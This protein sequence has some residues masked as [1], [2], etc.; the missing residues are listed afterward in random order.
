MKLLPLVKA[1]GIMALLLTFSAC[2]IT[3]NKMEKQLEHLETL[4]Y[5]FGDASVPPPYHRS[6]TI[7]VNKDSLVL[8]VDS[9]GDTLAEK[10]YTMPKN[11]LQ[12]LGTSLIKHNIHKRAEN[13]QSEGCT[14]G[15]TASIA[16][17]CGDQYEPFYASAYY[18]G[19]KTYGTLAG[20]VDSFLVDLKG[21]VPDL[22]AVIRS[23]E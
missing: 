20:N 8:T 2:I 17:T 19:G 14:G 9:Y 6:Y 1:C 3:K 23:T 4:T 7:V 15:T 21:F 12:E 13:K 18:C 10:T 5:A 11:G 16:Y 22:P